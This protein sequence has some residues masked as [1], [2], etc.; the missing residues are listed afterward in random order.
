VRN[1]YWNLRQAI[2]QIEIARIALEMAQVQLAQTRLRVEIGTMAPLETAQPEVTVAQQEQSLLQAEISWRNAE[3]ALKALLVSGLDDE[4]YRATINPTDLPTAPT[5]APTID[6]NAAMQT[7]LA[8]RTDLI[9]AR[10]NLEVTQLGMEVTRNALL[11]SLGFNTSLNLAGTG[12]PRLNNGV[13]V[14]PGGYLDA[15]RQ[16]SGFETPRW[17]MSFSFSY[18][19]GMAA[20]KANMA[21]ADIQLEQERLRLRTQE[22]SIQTEVTSAGLNIENSYRQLQSAVKSRQASERNLEAV[23]TRFEVGLANNFE[24]VT[25]Q[26]DLTSARLSEL[27]SMITYMNALAE[28]DR[29]QRFGR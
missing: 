2:E 11:P 27:R 3:L 24:V 21:R 29:V 26:R 18:P 8:E 23:Q 10:R 4:L 19:L 15:L 14:E 16:I 12:G 13:I 25:A 7:A 22:L 5:A 28:F 6:I 17:Q 1:A 9:I 20:A